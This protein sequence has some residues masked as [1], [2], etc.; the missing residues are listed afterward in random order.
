VLTD[1]ARNDRDARDFRQAV[2]EL[3]AAQRFTQ[4]YRPPSN[5]KV[6]RFNPTMLT[7]GPTSGPTGP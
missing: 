7:R 4:P 3:G 2:A 6:E 5:A 1:N